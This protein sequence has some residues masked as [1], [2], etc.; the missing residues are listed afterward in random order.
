V[1]GLSA[2]AELRAALPALLA[3]VAGAGT[4]GLAVSGG[5]DSLALMLLMAEWARQAGRPRLIVYSVDHGLRPE[6][7]GEVTFVL[8]EAARLGLTARGL[9]WEGAKPV[10]GVQAAARVARYRLICA[11]MRKDGAELLVTAHHQDDQAETVLMRLAHGSGLE[12]LRGMERFSVVEGVRVF[13]PFLE[14]PRAALAGVVSEAGLAPVADPSNADPHYERTRWRRVLPDLAELGLDGDAL[15]ALARRAGEADAA[16]AR[17]AEAAWETLVRFDAFGA[18][19]LP[20]AEFAALP[21][22]VAIKLLARLVAEVGGNRRPHGLGAIERLCAALPADG[23]AGQTVGGATIRRRGA[24]LWLTREPGRGTPADTMV[25]PR[26]VLAW[27]RRFRIANR[28]AG[29]VLVRMAGAM[30]RAGAEAITG[31]RLSAP[32]AAIRAAPLV[33]GD[34]GRPLALGCYSFSR[35][36]TVEFLRSAAQLP[37]P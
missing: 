12:G 21:R 30:T 6:A 33:A 11:A 26:Q 10:A 15:A 37:Q 20:S 13:R 34:D 19:Q 7:A 23:F 31:Q 9:L 24:T 29:P 1:P 27:D 4:V 8:A 28:S 14:V 25:G 16:V 35:D 32:A 36:V 18:A 17:W 5:A 2:P 22:A 3:P